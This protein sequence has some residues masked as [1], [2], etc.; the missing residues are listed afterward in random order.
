MEFFID[1]QLQFL[2][3]IDLSRTSLEPYDKPLR[4]CVYISHKPLRS[5]EFGLQDTTQ[6]PKSQAP[7]EKVH[8]PTQNLT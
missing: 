2:L 4:S 1:S 5:C 7:D 6:D 8:K 3:R